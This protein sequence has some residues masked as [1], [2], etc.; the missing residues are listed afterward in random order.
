[1]P[2]VSFLLCSE[3]VASS[4]IEHIDAGWRAFGNAVAGG[5]ASDDAKSQL[6]AA[7]ALIAMVDAAGTGS[8][9]P[10]DLL[11]AHQ[12]LMAI[13]HYTARDAGQI[14]MCRTG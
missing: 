9:R 5:K 6:A 4:K 2:L 13:D 11:D 1:M 3:S 8:I 10:D 7:K 14:R 12:L